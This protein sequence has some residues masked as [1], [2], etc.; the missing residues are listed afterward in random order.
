DIGTNLD[1]AQV[2]VQNRVAI[3]QPLLPQEVQ[4]QGITTKKQSTQ[5]IQF[6]VL[7]SPDDRYDS[8]YLSNFATLRI[9]DE[10]SRLPG[11]GL[12]SVRG[13]AQYS[14]RV[15]LDPPR[16]KA[17]GLTTQDVFAAIQE[18]NV[19]VAAGQIGQPPVPDSQTF[20]YTVTTL[21]RLTDITQ[22]ED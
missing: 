13:S 9:V 10:L 15:W 8:L 2:L 3:A 16:L 22:F 7:S 19:Q 1:I 12:A 18:Q 5:I 17:R 6:V 20:Q 11:V 4:R 14:M 21:G